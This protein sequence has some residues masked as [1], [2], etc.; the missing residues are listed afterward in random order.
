MGLS[1]QGM[2][3]W[4][5][6]ITATYR[7]IL[8]TPPSELTPI[9]ASKIKQRCGIDTF[10]SVP[11]DLSPLDSL[12]YKYKDDKSFKF[13][14]MVYNSLKNTT[15]VEGIQQCLLNFC[16]RLIAH[17]KRRCPGVMSVE[18]HS[19]LSSMPEAFARIE[20]FALRQPLT[21]LTMC[22]RFDHDGKFFYCDFFESDQSSNS[23]V[24][25]IISSTL[26][27]LRLARIVDKHIPA[28]CKTSL[29]PFMNPLDK[30]L[31]TKLKK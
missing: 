12:V 29:E 17:I 5:R 22:L 25:P 14:A 2:A 8:I 26:T 3:R 20:I 16:N 30:A 18:L 27:H 31:Q 6:V 24:R 10:P 4:L 19:R 21:K 23:M 13:P 9:I 1:N 7:E 11:E 15:H 28:F